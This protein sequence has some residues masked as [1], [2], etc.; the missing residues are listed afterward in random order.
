MKLITCLRLRIGFSNQLRV[1]IKQ[2]GY[3]ALMIGHERLSILLAHGA[4]VDKATR[5][6]AV[7]VIPNL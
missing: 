2:N 6:S 7:N 5:V 3:S 4:E 1:Y